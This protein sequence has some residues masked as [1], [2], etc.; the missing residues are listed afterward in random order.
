MANSMLLLTHSVAA[1]K[2]HDRPRR[3]T[4]TRARALAARLVQPG[5]PYVTK[6]ALGQVHAPGWVNSMS[7]RGVQHLVFDAEVVDGLVYAYR[8]REALQLPE[9]TVNGIRDAIHRTA[10]GKFWRYPTIRLNQVNWYAL[11]YAADA[12]VTG[13]PTLLKRDMSL[14]LRRFF[15]GRAPAARRKIGN[16]GPGMRFHYLPHMPLNVRQE[17]RLRR[18]REHRPDLHA[19][20]RPGAPGRHARPARVVPGLGAQ[21]IKRVISGYWTHSGYMN[22]DSGLGFDRWHQG[23]KFG[24][25]QEALIG[26]ATGATRCSPGA[27]YGALGEVRCSTAGSSFYGRESRALE[28]RASRIRCSSTSTPVPAGRRQ[29]PGSPWRA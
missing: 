7:G 16:F 1:M 8:A 6:P 24:L 15:N 10:R 26:V 2:G 17:R 3:A 23:K 14:Q 28:E 29:P 9:S 4:T 25:T 11:M 20:L 13:D 22:W 27:E 21:W 19:L 5:G 12:T 18:V